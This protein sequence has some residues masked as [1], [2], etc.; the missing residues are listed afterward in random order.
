VLTDRSQLSEGQNFGVYGTRIWKLADL[1]AKHRL[2]LAGLGW[3]SMPLHLVEQDLAA[4]ALVR[5]ELIDRFRSDY[6]MSL[7]RRIDTP[8]GPAAQWM[9]N[10]LGKE[11]GQA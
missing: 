6:K 4:G 7:I 10:Y 11:F 1:G 2:L 8:A 3:G 5:L 9:R